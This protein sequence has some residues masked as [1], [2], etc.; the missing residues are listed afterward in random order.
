[1]AYRH[2][3]RQHIQ[4]IKSICVLLQLY[5]Y[6]GYKRVYRVKQEMLG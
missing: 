2:M 3:P 4:R 6:K 5:K 1:M